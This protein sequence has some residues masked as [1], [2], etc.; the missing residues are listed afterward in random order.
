MT[1]PKF[2]WG[3]SGKTYTDPA[4][5]DAPTI[6][7]PAVKIVALPVNGTPF[8]PPKRI[9]A[10]KPGTATVTD[11]SGE[12]IPGFPLTGGEQAIAITAINALATSTQV[13]GL[14]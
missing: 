14:Y 12:V 3:L 4:E 8:N 11:A 6:L 13:W 1:A 9:I 10:D 2:Q 7:G 5:Y